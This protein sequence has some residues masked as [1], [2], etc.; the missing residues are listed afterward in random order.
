MKR[1][2]ARVSLEVGTDG[3]RAKERGAAADAGYWD[4]LWDTLA[5]DYDAARTG[6]LPHQLRATVG[7]RVAVPARVL[8]AGCGLGHFTVAMHARGFDA[9]GLDWGVRAVERLRSTF[10]DVDVQV[11]DVRRSPF[12]PDSFDV[13]YS[14][15]VCEHFEPGPDEVLR[16]AF[17]V[18]RPGGLLFVS[19]PHLNAL[20]RRRWQGSD[21]PGDAPFYQ[22]LF[23]GSGMTATLERLGFDVIDT[24]PY[25]TWATLAMEWPVLERIRLGKLAGV[26]DLVP[27]VRRIGANCIWTARKPTGRAG[28]P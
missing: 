8:E 4:D 9:V 26:L 16:D 6:H 7:A 11:G 10:P 3:L 27:G 24:T 23:T 1:P 25:A 22:Y 14:P 2:G 12:P 13:V 17:R 28:E 19:T 18:L 5:L 20:R 21:A 15:G